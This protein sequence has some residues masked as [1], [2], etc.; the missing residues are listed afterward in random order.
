MELDFSK[1]DNLGSSQKPA[2]EPKEVNHSKPLK[3][4]KKPA[5]GKKEPQ[6]QALQRKANDRKKQLEDS[7]GI[8]KEYQK[9]KRLTNEIVAEIT[10]G[11]QQGADIHG[12]FLKAVEALAL[13]TNDTLLYDNARQNLKTIY[14]IGLKETYALELEREDTQ[15]RLERLTQALNDAARVEDKERLKNAIEAHQ[16]HL[17]AIQA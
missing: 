1:I 17:K 7:A 8:L 13:T 12:L 11:I 16:K 3:T 14:G 5:E 6:A 15:T 4:A 2:S 9:N 10:K